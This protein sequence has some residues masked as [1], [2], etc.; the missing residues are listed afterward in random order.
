MQGAYY[1]NKEGD[2]LWK[3]EREFLGCT[4]EV[5]FH[6]KDVIAFWPIPKRMPGNNPAEGRKFLV[7]I[8]GEMVNLGAK[9]ESVK[10]VAENN[11]S[12]PI[13]VFDAVYKAVRERKEQHAN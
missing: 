6:H 5:Y 8:V 2:V 3:D 9:Y 13:Q 10:H 11:F 12:I 7:G 4:P 1:L